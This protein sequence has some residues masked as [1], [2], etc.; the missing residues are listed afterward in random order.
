[1]D[2][3]GRMVIIE[4]KDAIL[5]DADPTALSASD[6]LASESDNG[7]IDRV[8]ASTDKAEKVK[9]KVDG[10][11]IYSL[12]VDPPVH[13][14]VKSMSLLVVIRKLARS[15]RA[16]VDIISTFVY[17]QAFQLLPVCSSR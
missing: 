2:L 14:E 9:S 12:P 10:F 4:R 17:G 15:P 3:L 16:L 8:T 1:M 6:A 13:V 11:P 5:W 7:I